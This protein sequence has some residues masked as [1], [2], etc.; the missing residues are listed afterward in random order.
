MRPLNIYLAGRCKDLDDGGKAWRQ[1][2]VKILETVAE[3]TNTEVCVVNPTNY[4]GYTEKTYKSQKQ[5]KDYYFDRI[6]KC[7]IVLVNLDGTDVSIGT[8]QEVQ[9]AV[10][11]EKTVIGFGKAN[12]YPWIAEVDCQVVFDSLHEAIDYIRDYFLVGGLR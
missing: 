10:D 11:K 2:A 6:R 3:W 1:E 12:M 9:Y 8:A 7:D 4:F 5:I